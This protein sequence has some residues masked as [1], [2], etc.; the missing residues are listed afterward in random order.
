MFV[1][2]YC[3]Q[4]D[5][6][7]IEIRPLSRRAVMCFECD[8]VWD[9]AAEVHDDKGCSFEDFMTKQGMAPDWKLA[10]KLRKVERNA[11]TG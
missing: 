2:P 3:Q 8:T 10:E 9:V 11:D 7:E 5:V 4:D 6:W 1:C